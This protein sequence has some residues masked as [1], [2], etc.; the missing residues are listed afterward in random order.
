MKLQFQA[1]TTWRQLKCIK[2][3]CLL[4]IFTDNEHVFPN[5]EKL[6]SFFQFFQFKW[7]PCVILTH[8]LNNTV[9][10]G[11]KHKNELFS[12]SY[13]ESHFCNV[14]FLLDVVKIFFCLVSCCNHLECKPQRIYGHAQFSSMIL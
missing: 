1:K 10:S 6:L 13:L 5:V 11:S 7:K 12:E 4:P 3:L 2:L 9:I 8:L 14:Q